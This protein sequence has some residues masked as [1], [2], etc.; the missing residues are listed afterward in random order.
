MN[1]WFAFNSISEC[2][3]LTCSSVYFWMSRHVVFELST[4]SFESDAFNVEGFLISIDSDIEWKVCLKRCIRFLLMMAK[5]SVC[6]SSFISFTFRNI[7]NLLLCS[8]VSQFNKSCNAKHFSCS[9]IECSLTSS[10]LLKPRSHGVSITVEDL[11]I[12]HSECM[13]H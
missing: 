3:E 8:Q 1:D 11:A 6:L 5:C 9:D 7:T 12:F 4:E 13:Y 2:H 10:F